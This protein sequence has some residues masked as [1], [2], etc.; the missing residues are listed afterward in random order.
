MM[1]KYGTKPSL[2]PRCLDDPTHLSGDFAR[3]T[4]ARVQ[5]ERLR[6]KHRR[7]LSYHFGQI[8][9]SSTQPTQQN[10]LYIG[11]LPVVP[12]VGHSPM[13]RTTSPPTK[14]KSE[15]PPDSGAKQP[16][17][18]PLGLAQRQTWPDRSP[19]GHRPGAVV[20]VDPDL[21]QVPP[22]VHHL[23]RLIRR[24]CGETGVLRRRIAQ[25]PI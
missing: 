15:N 1:E 20:Q 22:A 8:S 6:V 16:L 2:D 21:N 4:V 3:P 23:R 14:A 5:D 10:R 12:S 19:L 11:Y 24:D 25:F 9:E 7:R 17:P 18:Q 13:L